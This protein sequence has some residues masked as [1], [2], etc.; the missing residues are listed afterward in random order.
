MI[1][2]SSSHIKTNK[3]KTV[4]V[5]SLSHYDGDRLLLVFVTFLF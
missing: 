4:L 3:Q 5:E 2:Q 1:P